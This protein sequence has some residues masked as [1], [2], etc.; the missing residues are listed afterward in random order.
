MAPS[1]DQHSY[2]AKEALQEERYLWMARAFSLVALL[3]LVANFLMLIALSGLMPLMRVQPFYLQSQS[4]DRQVISIQ[5]P[6]PEE[7]DSDILQEALV[8]EYLL[9]RFGIGADLSEVTR[10][11]GIDGVVHEMSNESVFSDFNNKEAEPMLKQ[12]GDD[13]LTRNVKI[14]SVNRAER[15][16]NSDVWVAEI[17]LTDMSQKSKDFR[18]SLWSVEMIVSFQNLGRQMDWSQRLK[19][20]LGFK[21]IGFGRKPSKGNATSL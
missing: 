8:R 17:E 3:A 14:L 18:V 20:P 11:W 2:S 12:A 13:S 5:R 1:K 19:N 7:L 10:R 21:V 4:K 15:R 9:A 16:Q 6:S